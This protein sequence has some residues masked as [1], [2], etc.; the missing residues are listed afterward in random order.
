MKYLDT[1]RSTTTWSRRPEQ[2]QWRWPSLLLPLLAL[3][4]PIATQAGVQVDQSPLIVSKPLPPNVMFIYDDSGSMAWTYLPDDA[5]RINTPAGRDA[6]RNYQ[7]YDPRVTYEVPPRADGSLYPTPIFPNGYSNPFSSNN[8]NDIL[9]DSN[10]SDEGYYVDSRYVNSGSCRSAG[11]EW[12]RISRRS[13]N[14]ECRFYHYAFTYIDPDTNVQ[15]Y[16]AEDCSAFESNC[17]TDPDVQQSVANY[18]SYYRTRDLA[19]KSG[20]LSAFVELDPEYRVGFGSINN[21]GSNYISNSAN[22]TFW[23][24]GKRLAGVERF[25]AIDETGTQREKFWGW[26]EEVYPSGGTPLRQSLKAAGEYYAT[27]DHPWEAGYDKDGSYDSSQY[28]CRQSYTLLMT[29]GYWNGGSP[30][31]GNADNIVGTEITSAD[32]LSS[33][34]YSPRKPFSDTRSNQ[35]ADVAMAYWKR[36]L[37]PG[38]ANNVPT[39]GNDPAFWQH[40]T[41]FTIGLGVEPNLTNDGGGSMADVFEWARTGQPGGIN[42]TAFNWGNDE[43][44]DLAHAAV[45]GRGGFYSA[46]DPQTFA[47]GMRNALASIGNANGAGDS[48]TLSGGESVTEGTLRYTAGYVTGEWTGSLKA[49]EYSEASGDFD[50]EKWTAAGNFPAAAERNIWTHNADGTAVPF[51]GD[52]L[53]AA[54]RTALAANIDTSFNVPA[55]DIVAYLR[56]ERSYEDS[57]TTPLAGTLRGRTSLLGDIFSSTPV[58]VGPPASKYEAF[59]FASQGFDGLDDYEAF[60]EAQ[61]DRT[62]MLY[63]AANDG[64]L[65]AF[66]AETGVE[67]FAFIPGA[68]L[69]ASGDASLAR[70]A[71]PRYGLYSPVDGRQTVPH[72][73]YND[74]EMATQNVYLDGEWKTILVGTT[75][76]GPTP[77]IYALDITDPSVLADPSKTEGALLWERSLGD[78]SGNNAWI[79]QSL[80][81]PTLWQVKDGNSSKWV[82]LV[83]NGPNSDRDRAALLQFDLANGNLTVYE[84]D[85]ATSNGLAAP[86]G[87]STDSSTGIA[88]YAFAGDL[89]G[90]VWQ[91]ELAAN[92]GSGSLVFKARGPT[93]QKQPITARMNATVHPKDGSIWV[94]FGTGKYLAEED[95]DDSRVQT[96]YGLRAQTKGSGKPVSDGNTNRSKLVKRS[97]VAEQTVGAVTARATSAGSRSELDVDDKVGWYMDLISPVHG[98][99]GERIL[100]VSQLLGSYLSVNTT[101]PKVGD[102]CNTLPP[103]ATMMVDPFSGASSD[104]AFMDITGDGE[105]DMIGDLPVNGFVSRVGASGASTFATDPEGNVIGVHPDLGGGIFK[106][107]ALDLGGSAAESLNWHELIAQ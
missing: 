100:Y 6:S 19:A 78:G 86:T 31:V 62:A 34:Q 106:M 50:V 22:H 20:I 46:G 43:I 47:E 95:I 64:M 73:Y 85:G 74:G 55:T 26:M 69:S 87:V 40:M 71:N 5:P 96:W 4:L 79:G 94:F 29:D 33:Y 7:Y 21:R 97:I 9:S 39:S 48:A 2:R 107:P 104:R 103:G 44:A 92:G 18:Y 32:G 67:K 28:S 25:G 101:I 12:E 57:D 11:G 17:T 42:E 45:N 1:T 70:L 15:H 53:S 23:K 58:Y 91:F 68:L 83:G 59:R 3:L 51:Q 75:G 36:D 63:V 13:R 84:T 80:G 30:S 38:M 35:L 24:E 93:G 102:P 41:T 90:N 27:E 60:A 8:T 88:D 76:R 14:Y 65:H 99:E 37:R 82:A 72:Q 52:S 98:E 54:Q 49:S 56:G 16:V 77:T 61:E 81:R 66:D 10:Y 105:Y 89:Q